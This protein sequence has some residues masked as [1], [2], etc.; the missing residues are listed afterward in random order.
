VR[1]FAKT[2]R[3]W[4]NILLEEEKTNVGRTKFFHTVE[5]YKYLLII[6]KNLVD[7]SKRCTFAA[8]ISRLED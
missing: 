7:F 4:N 1:F 6:S 8:S 2:V 5:N 3:F